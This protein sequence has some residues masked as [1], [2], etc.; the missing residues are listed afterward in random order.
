M[1]PQS[2]FGSINYIGTLRVTLTGELERKHLCGTGRT[3]WV[4]CHSGMLRG[5]KTQATA[6]TVWWNYW[7][8]GSWVAVKR[9]ISVVQHTH[10]PWPIPDKNSWPSPHQFTF[11][12][13]P[14]FLTLKL[15][16]PTTS[17][18]PVFLTHQ[19]LCTSLEPPISGKVTILSVKFFRRAH[20]CVRFQQ[21]KYREHITTSLQDY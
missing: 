14:I 11:L 6:K 10:H 9:Q 8:R 15:I 16:L 5:R 21:G 17:R 3:M 12:D 19:C 4:L 20:T 2:S 18:K 7:V 1:D 13:P